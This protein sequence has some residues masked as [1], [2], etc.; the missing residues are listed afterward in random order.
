MLLIATS[1]GLGC[2]DKEP[3]VYTNPDANIISVD[4]ETDYYE[5]IIPNFD[6]MS[7][8]WYHQVNQDL[9]VSVMD[10]IVE[11]DF[12]MYYIGD[13]DAIIRLVGQGYTVGDFNKFNFNSNGK[14]R[15][16]K[17]VFRMNK[18]KSDNSML[19]FVNSQSSLENLLITN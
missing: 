13:T 9:R 12:T 3:L 4:D 11:D 7:T 19:I 18:V 5:K 1:F 2:I 6:S 14:H 17:I 15:V 10:V 16:Y 8:G